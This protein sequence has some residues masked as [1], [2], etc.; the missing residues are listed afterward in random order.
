MW[1]SDYYTICNFGF[2]DEFTGIFST[3]KGYNEKTDYEEKANYCTNLVFCL[4]HYDF[5][6][7][8][9]NTAQ[10]KT[11]TMCFV[12]YLTGSFNGK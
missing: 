12:E 7:L 10:T 11:Y 1:R 5:T 9:A 4:N 2:T 3:R 6:L 8:S